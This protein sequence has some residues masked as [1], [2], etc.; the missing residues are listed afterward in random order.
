M[1]PEEPLLP[2]QPLPEHLWGDL[3]QF[4]SL[5]AEDLEWR[6]WERPIP[7]REAAAIALP[8]Q[9]NLSSTALVPGIVINAGRQAIGLSRWLSER[10]PKQISVANLE[11]GAIILTTAQKERW[12]LATYQDDAVREAGQGF[13]GRKGPS[14]GI[15]FLLIQPDDSGVTHAGLWILKDDR[16][17]SD[18]QTN[19]SAQV[20]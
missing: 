4:A 18:R 13:E 2:P 5:P 17:W 8:S 10:K 1:T 14:K 11:L 7:F 9:Q 6:L 16:F 12:I 3:W 20:V 15:H 19:G